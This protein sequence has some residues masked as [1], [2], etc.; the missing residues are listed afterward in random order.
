MKYNYNYSFLSRW[1]EANPKISAR[2][3]LRAMG[4]NS[5][6]SLDSWESMKTPLPTI[7]LLRFCN[8]FSVPLSAFIVDNDTNKNDDNEYNKG[9]VMPDANDQYEPDGGYIANDAKRQIGTRALRDP[10]DV[11]V[12]KSVVPGLT[13]KKVTKVD[14]PQVNEP[15]HHAD[16]NPSPAPQPVVPP[17]PAPSQSKEQDVS[18]TTLNKM[19]DII[20]E[21]QKQIAEQ[22]KYIAKLTNLLGE[23]PAHTYGIAADEIHHTSDKQ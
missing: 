13:H 18:M 6:G 3:I 11:E 19:L 21:Q 5:N 22:Q 20:A 9:F 23:N 12:V 16:P 4:T 1:M 15:S 17:S 7:A 10:L 2:A 8:A 14:K